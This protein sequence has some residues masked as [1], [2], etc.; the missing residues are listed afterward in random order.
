M[1]VYAQVPRSVHMN[2]YLPQVLHF[3]VL[4]KPHRA[5]FIISVTKVLD[6]DIA[7]FFIKEALIGD[8]IRYNV[9]EGYLMIGTLV[10]HSLSIQ[11]V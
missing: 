11:R 7:L 9:G 6:I 1:C 4:T 3:V 10:L 5:F 2:P 8:S